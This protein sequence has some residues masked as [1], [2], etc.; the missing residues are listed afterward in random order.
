MSVP[1][2]RRVPRRS[3]P[4]PTF[5]R[6]RQTLW[7]SRPHAGRL[8]LYL[9]VAYEAGALFVAVRVG[10]GLRWVAAEAALTA[11]EAE[12]WAATGFRRDRRS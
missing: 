11:H 2:S 1:S 6:A 10:H 4:R 9:G 7:A 12:A 5:P 3:S 8:G